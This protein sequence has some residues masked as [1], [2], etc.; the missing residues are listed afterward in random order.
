M[1]NIS[2]VCMTFLFCLTTNSVN[3][4]AVDSTGTERLYGLSTRVE[5]SIPPQIPATPPSGSVCGSATIKKYPW[6]SR[7]SNSDNEILIMELYYVV[8]LASC[9]GSDVISLTGHYIKSKIHPYYE[10]YVSGNGSVST[11]TVIP[12]CPTGYTTKSQHNS[13]GPF[14]GILNFGLFFCSKN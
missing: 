8:P 13:F 10:G 12:L 1:K 2:T 3:A 5:N 6:D 7:V 4:Q 9:N 11:L 14:S